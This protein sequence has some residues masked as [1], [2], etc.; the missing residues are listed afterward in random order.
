MFSLDCANARISYGYSTSTP[1]TVTLIIASVSSSPVNTGS[2][3]TVTTRNLTV[4]AG[5][6][7]VADISRQISGGITEQTSS[8][9]LLPRIGPTEP[10]VYIPSR[11]ALVLAKVG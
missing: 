7:T 10:V 6:I 11:V 8:K 9:V 2:Y 3:W 5:S 1:P 4:K